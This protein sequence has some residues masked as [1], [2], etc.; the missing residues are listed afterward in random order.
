M[1]KVICPQVSAVLL[2]TSS[3]LVYGEKNPS[4]ELSESTILSGSHFFKGSR[5]DFSFVEGK[6]IYLIIT[7]SSQSTMAVSAWTPGKFVLSPP[8]LGALD[9]RYSDDSATVGKSSYSLEEGRIFLV[10]FEPGKS[11]A[12]QINAEFNWEGGQIS[13]FLEKRLMNLSKE[14]PKFGA[15][16]APQ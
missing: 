8:D 16:L 10:T 5:V 9:F 4:A 11:S 13:T 12:E 6:L 7:R 1:M 14:S 15:F 2:G 3:P